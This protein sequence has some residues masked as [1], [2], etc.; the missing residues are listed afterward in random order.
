[1]V[2]HYNNRVDPEIKAPS[3]LIIDDTVDSVVLLERILVD[4]GFKVRSETN[5][6]S[7]IESAQS[8]TPDL[9]ILDVSMPEMDGFEVCRR[10][11]EI[12]DLKDVPVIFLSAM[13]SVNDRDKALSTGGAD[14]INK[15]FGID[16]LID[17]IEKL[18]PNSMSQEP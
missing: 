6:F 3:I 9:I 17:G 7:A 13:A 11:K 18:L 5:C 8:D 15:P 2:F 1:M 12:E 16:E 10:L 14:Y 4:Q